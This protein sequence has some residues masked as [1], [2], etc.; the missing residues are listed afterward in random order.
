[1]VSQA[2]QRAHNHLS[3]NCCF[4]CDRHTRGLRYTCFKQFADLTQKCFY[5]LVLLVTPPKY[6]QVGHP[7]MGLRGA[8]GRAR[9]CCPSERIMPLRVY[10]NKVYQCAR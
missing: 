8:E 6:G 2:L 9:P 7:T 10:R 4:A 5:W 1:M 3:A